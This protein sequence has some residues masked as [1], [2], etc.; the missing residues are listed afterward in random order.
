MQETWVQ[1]LDWEDPLEKGMATHSSIPAYRIPWIEEP[2]G[3]Q[4]QTLLKQLSMQHACMPWR[5]WSIRNRGQ[6]RGGFVC[7]T[8][9]WVTS[10]TDITKLPLRSDFILK[11]TESYPS[12]WWSKQWG[13][14]HD[15]EISLHFIEITLVT[16]WRGI[17]GRKECTW[18]C[19]SRSLASLAWNPDRKL[20]WIQV[21][22]QGQ[23][24]VL[25]WWLIV[26][27]DGRD[28]RLKTNIAFSGLNNE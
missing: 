10:Q 9:A 14:E 22:L 23:V 13:S 21:W 26:L 19:L 20:A 12:P 27:W 5:G 15:R 1:S 11:A 3:L 25:R 7:N 4:S 28:S 17:K 8:C 18:W 24:A 6:C 16:L 2:G